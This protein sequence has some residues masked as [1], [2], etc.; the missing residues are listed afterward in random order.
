VSTSGKFSVG[1][2]NSIPIGLHKP[3]EISWIFGNRCTKAMTVLQ[4]VLLLPV[5]MLVCSAQLDKT[6]RNLPTSINGFRG[7]G[8]VWP[9]DFSHL[10]VDLDADEDS[11]LSCYNTILPETLHKPVI[12]PELCLLSMYAG[13]IS[14]DFGIAG[15]SGLSLALSRPFSFSSG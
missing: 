7:K 1:I 8:T 5:W 2:G 9:K 12:F 11:E 3:R 13:M 10:T 4:A 14:A 15:S 6:T